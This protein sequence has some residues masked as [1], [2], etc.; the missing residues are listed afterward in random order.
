MTV[1]LLPTILVNQIAAGEVV[2]RPAS[3]VKE[4]VENSIDAGA[5]QINVVMRDGGR[6]FLQVQDNGNGMNRADLELGVERHATSKLPNEDLFNIQT[7]GF[8][9][10]A[11][12]SI[13]AV[14]RLKISSNT[15][16]QENGWTLSVEGGN[17]SDLSPC[18]H[19]AG[20]TIEVR[21]LFFATPA[22][23][24]FLKTSTTES[25]HINQV[26]TRL[27][28]AHPE[29]GFTL[30]DNTRVCF[31]YMPQSSSDEDARLKRLGEIM[32]QE[33]TENAL[34]VSAQSQ[35][36]QLSGFVGLPT[37]SRGNANFQYLF[38]NGR[39]V[40]DKVLAGALRAAY[41]DFLPRDRHPLVALFL[42]LDP[43]M[44][45]MNVHPAKTEVRF[46]DA[47]F[48]RGLLISSIQKALNSAGH[49]AST[50]IAQSAMQS[51]GTA[52]NALPRAPASSTPTSTS[53]STPASVTTIPSAHS[54]N[55][56]GLSLAPTARTAAPAAA[57]TAQIAEEEILADPQYP[58]GVAKTQLKQTYIV[59]ETE[60]GLV[61]VDQHA[62][63]ERLVY[64]K[65]KQ[66]QKDRGVARQTLLV[67]EVVE[68]PEAAIEHLLQVID[69]LFQFGLV[70]EK[71]GESA[72]LVREV[73]ALLGQV[74][75]KRLICDLSDELE[76]LGQAY[77]LKEKVEEVCATIACHGSVRAGRQLSLEEMNA[78]LREMEKTPHSGQ[79]N[80]GRPTY[81]ELP[82]N[83][84]EKLFGR[85]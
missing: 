61:I 49:R 46:R 50:T 66:G 48:V 81:V 25:N 59:A 20:T 56:P 28:M 15:R 74:N 55:L 71:F 24:K 73:P 17:K 7:L 58:L 54:P 11:L 72:V 47:G 23:L 76:S 33:F 4:L 62:A 65:M 78:L 83:D 27:A 84:V 9:G 75:A 26:L 80:H 68:L 6:S 57:E 42:E 67:P 2:E 70:L 31:N 22:R 43:H 52:S 36:Y 40:K 53:Y 34:A 39:P 63:H 79:C 60:K 69:D 12:P 77:S 41:Q 8:R 13:G 5:T 16:G 82:W 3:I 18:V 37:L 14:S 44:V 1:R 38:V 64:E 51:F 21:D 29:I 35:G 30:K 19:P 45:D 85:R 32:G 10:E